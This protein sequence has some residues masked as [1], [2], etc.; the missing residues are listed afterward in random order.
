MYGAVQQVFL[1]T[2]ATGRPQ[3][4][5]SVVFETDQ[6]CNCALKNDRHS[7]AGKVVD[8]KPFVINATTKSGKSVA[9]AAFTEANLRNRLPEPDIRQN[10]DDDDKFDAWS[11]GPGPETNCVATFDVVRATSKKMMQFQPPPPPGPKPHTT[12]TVHTTTT[13][14]STAANLTPPPAAVTVANSPAKQVYQEDENANAN[15]IHLLEQQLRQQQEEKLRLE[16]ANRQLQEKLRQEEEANREIMNQM[17]TS[18]RGPSQ[19]HYL[20]ASA[21]PDPVPTFTVNHEVLEPPQQQKN[22]PAPL[23]AAH[24]QGSPAASLALSKGGPLTGVMI[25]PPPNHPP[26]AKPGDQNRAA[27]NLPP[28]GFDFAPAPAVPGGHYNAGTKLIPRVAN[29]ITQPQ[30]LTDDGWYELAASPPAHIQEQPRPLRHLPHR[31]PAAPL[32]E[33]RTF[34]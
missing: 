6:D 14:T 15:A 28:P 26:P 21:S 24:N 27:L 32:P 12:T 11:D 3:G 10:Y 33:P 29:S 16:E 34:D 18:S 5:A 19:E 1:K 31:P 9:S 20:S 17:Q 4:W 8:V 22:T 7:L 25:P 30:K 23:P 2:D 13:T